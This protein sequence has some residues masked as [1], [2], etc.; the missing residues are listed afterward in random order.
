MMSTPTRFARSVFSLL[1]ASV[2]MGLVSI[3]MAG[4]VGYLQ[5]NG[6]INVQPAGADKPLRMTENDYAVFSNDRIDT[7]EG[8]AVLVL[9]GGGV[10]GLSEGSSARVR[11]VEGSGDL[12][13]ALD[14]GSAV[15]SM[16]ADAG[17]LQFDVDGVVFAAVEATGRPADPNARIGEVA[18][19]LSIDHNRQVNARARAGD[20]RVL[21][22]AGS[23]PAAPSMNAT[24]V[25]YAAPTG[26]ESAMLDSQSFDT[27]TSVSEGSAAQVQTAAGGGVAAISLM[28]GATSQAAPGAVETGAGS[29]GAVASRGGGSVAMVNGAEGSSWV[30]IDEEDDELQS[31]SP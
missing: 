8:S 15:Y 14:S 6:K 22:P 7:I 2:L 11:K 31:I 9:N 12:T 21:R 17:N 13:V 5:I 24:A 28:S 23:G 18:G 4:P 19:T 16:P 10:I 27:L 29:D 20:I 25:A 26:A 3:A 1:T 30:V